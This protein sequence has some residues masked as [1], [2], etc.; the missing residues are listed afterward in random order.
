MQLD[1][2]LS[3]SALPL[4]A[5][6]VAA[7]L[8]G[9]RGE[10][11]RL[12]VEEGLGQGISAAE[13]QLRMILPAQREIGRLWEENLISVAQEHLATSISQLAMA[14]LYPHLPR[15]PV[16]GRRVL[17]ACVEGELHDMGARMGADF[18]EMAGFDVHFLGANVSTAHLV[19]AIVSDRPDLLGLSVMMHFHLASLRRTV[20]A[21][22]KV[23]ASLP[24]LV[25]GAIVTAFP[26]LAE[27]L[28]IE[29]LGSSADD[30]AKHCVHLFEQPPL[31]SRP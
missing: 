14:R 20:D 4:T 1:L 28:G 25:A 6:Y 7:Q 8:T 9:N 15:G 19:E 12:L 31:S 13:L 30:L 24:I 26:G 23:A 21:V 5:P 17:V 11:L 3:N 27:E 22:R 18:L 10:A 16:N 2:R 29:A